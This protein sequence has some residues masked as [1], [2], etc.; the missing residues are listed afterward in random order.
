MATLRYARDPKRK[1]PIYL[2]V[3]DLGREEPGTGYDDDGCVGGNGGKTEKKKIR[4]K[5]NNPRAEYKPSC[6][7]LQLSLRM[8][9]C[10]ICAGSRVRGRRGWMAGERRGGGG[11]VGLGNEK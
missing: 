3:E 10:Y 11:G 2:I 6:K 7:L 9:V 8:R 1:H 4:E 5:K